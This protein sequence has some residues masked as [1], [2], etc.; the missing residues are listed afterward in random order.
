MDV[1]AGPWSIR[2]LVAS[3]AVHRA[4]LAGAAAI[5]AVGLLAGHLL[6][7]PKVRIDGRR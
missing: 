2:R 1:A 6:L 4:L 3:A 7:D 5:A